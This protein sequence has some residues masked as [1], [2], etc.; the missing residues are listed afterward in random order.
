M[1]RKGSRT[2][3]NLFA[4][5][6]GESQAHSKYTFYAEK[7]R[8]DG[9]EQIAS[10]FEETA[11]NEMAHA[12]IWLNQLRGG[13]E[14]DTLGSLEDAAGGEHYE[15]AEMYPAFAKTAKEEGFDHIAFL[16]EQ[17][18]EIERM[19][20]ERFRRLIGNVEDGM[21]FS[22]D[23][24]AVWQCRICGHIVVGKQ[25]PQVCPVCANPQAFFQIKAENY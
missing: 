13:K 24:D 22:R 3:A 11:A 5:F 17:V 14:P 7:A 16:F 12:G 2:E 15:W 20:E 6:A 25:V 8:K 19:H 10:L 9:Y 4:A 21:V 1:E 18:A 23:G